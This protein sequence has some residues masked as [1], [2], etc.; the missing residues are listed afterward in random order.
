MS[1]HTIGTGYTLAKIGGDGVKA[2]AVQVTGSASYDTG[3]SV[4]DFSSIFG[5]ELRSVIGTAQGA[6]AYGLQYVPAGSN[7]PATAKLFVADADGAQIANATDLSGVVFDCV[8][9]GTDA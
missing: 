9:T 6:V 2:V 8:A 5:D 4:G 1:A 7:A 3:G